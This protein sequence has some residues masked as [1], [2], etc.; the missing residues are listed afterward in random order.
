MLIVFDVD[1]TLIGGEAFDWKCFND[2]F[3]A[4]SGKSMTD[5]FW[6]SIDEVTAKAVVH[7][8]LA[9]FPEAERDELEQ[10]I[11]RTFLENLQADHAS[12]SDAFQ[13]A[14]ETIDLIN[15]LQSSDQYDMAIATGDW[16]PSISFKLSKSGIDL[17]AIPHATASERYARADIIRLAAERAKGNL[18]KTIYV[19]DG[20]WDLRACRQLGIPFI[21]TGARTERLYQAGAK[22][23]LPKLDT[24]PFLEIL[25]QIQKQ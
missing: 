16:L 2:A 21:G 11:S 4:V 8:A 7:I 6:Q 20:V 18:E 23:I 24:E 12:N 14:P 17:N 9:E 3:E 1:G 5:A 19:G 15:T 10:R 22:W 25:D 13:A